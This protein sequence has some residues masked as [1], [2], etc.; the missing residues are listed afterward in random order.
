M[1]KKARKKGKRKTSVKKSTKKKTVK[2]TA[3]KRTTKKKAVRKVAKPKAVARKPAR[4]IGPRKSPVAAV[5]LEL[6]LGLIGIL[7]IGHFY[8]GRIGRGVFFLLGFWVLM[9]IEFVIL[10]YVAAATFGMGV[11]VA[12]PIMAI[13]N[14]IVVII[15]TVLAYKEAKAY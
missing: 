13:I 3:K 7:G 5:L 6:L 2:K 8:N 10:I 15:S 12:L 4:P 1:A 11:V 14:L 9:F